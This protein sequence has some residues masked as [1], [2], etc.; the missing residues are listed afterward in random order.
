[1]KQFYTNAPHT[2]VM[3]AFVFLLGL[4]IPTVGGMYWFRKNQ[5]KLAH[6][7]KIEMEGNI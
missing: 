1:M 3:G 6:E 2:P 7:K 5:S 4:V